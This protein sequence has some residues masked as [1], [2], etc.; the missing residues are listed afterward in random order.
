M[1]MPAQPRRKQTRT[2]ANADTAREEAPVHHHRPRRSGP[3][4]LHGIALA[5]QISLMSGVGLALLAPADPVMAQQASVAAEPASQRSWNLPAASL[6]ESLNRFAQQAGLTL[7]ADPALTAGRSAPAISG[8]YTVRQV[9]VRLLAGTGLEAVVGAESVSIRRAPVSSAAGA[10]PEVK[11]AAT[12]Q[13][14]ASTSYRVRRASAATKTDTALIDTPASVTVLT[15]A[16]MRDQMAQTVDEVLRNVS[17]VT[18]SA[19]TGNVG[20]THNNYLRGFYT[21]SSYKD[22][23]RVNLTGN[24]SLDNIETVEVVKG[25]ASVLYG[26]I[27]PGGVIAYTRKKPQAEPYRAVFVTLGSEAH[28]K[29]TAD[30]TGPLNTSGELSYRLVAAALDTNLH[31]DHAKQKSHFIAPSLRYQSADWLVD[32][33][34]EYGREQGTM[35]YG[36]QSFAHAALPRPD[37]SLPRRLFLGHPDNIRKQGDDMAYVQ[38]TRRFGLDSSI[39]ATYSHARATHESYSY[40][41]GSYNPATRMYTTYGTVIPP[42]VNND[43]HAF[44]L[45]GTQGWTLGDTR[46]K[47]TVGMEA[48]NRFWNYRECAGYFMNAY[49]ASIDAPDYTH[50]PL[51]LPRGCGPASGVARY[52]GQE[53]RQRERAMFAQNTSWITERL[54]ALTGLR[55]ARIEIENRNTTQGTINSAQKDAAVTGSLG[56]LYKATPGLS[57]YGSYASSFEQLVGRRFDGG[58]FEPT[59]GRQIEMGFK[60]EVG[61]A[62]FL[63][64]SVFRLEQRNL[65]LADPVHIGFSIQEGKVRSDGVELEISGEV[66]PRLSMTGGVAYL[67]N[68]VV[69]GPNDGRRLDGVYRTK[70]SLWAN[71]RLGEAWT[72]GGGVFHHGDS[73]VDA[74]EVPPATL[75]DLA[76]TWSQPLGQG[77]ATVQVNLKNVFDKRDYVGNFI[78]PG[79]QFYVRF[80][81]EF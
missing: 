51:D 42:T 23:L 1:P 40:R 67:D 30:L 70:A 25:P 71:Y 34:L 44:E 7:A 38:A 78:Q 64:G 52:D 8:S 37:T 43:E 47:L 14:E 77:R 13:S 19:T 3:R 26:S 32:A 10:L 24:L 53:D 17:S 58:T 15:E 33:G 36:T 5:V 55:Y 50:S 4:R 61:K 45:R 27:Q 75:V 60:Q 69:G 74:S 79:R 54:Q 63:T 81:Y 72:L 11:V 18:P 21:G 39:T 59:E 46:N 62:A 49:T 29:L 6:E 31:V 12:Q 35:D 2:P 76:A 65:T 57:L 16:V 22:G 80:G 66:L 9:L 41:L 28:K 56:L 68:Q 20:G 73:Y 48:R